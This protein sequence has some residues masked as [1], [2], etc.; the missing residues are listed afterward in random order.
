[1]ITN[2]E[3]PAELQQAASEADQIDFILRYASDYPKEYAYPLLGF[4]SCWTLFTL[5]FIAVFFGPFVLYGEVD[6]EINGVPTHITEDN[7][8][9]LYIPASFLGIFVIIGLTLLIHGLTSAFAKGGWYIGH[10]DG[11]SYRKKDK[12]ELTKWED[13]S[14][15][16]VKGEGKKGDVI[17]KLKTG[18][19]FHI[20]GIPD[21]QKISQI[22]QLHIATAASA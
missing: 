22:C 14:S 15:V 16:E 7:I 10:K 13:F 1:M 21:P 19:E 20:S 3:L 17:L 8:F 18:G 5:F 12:T 4:G 9:E 6:I 11:L 2:A